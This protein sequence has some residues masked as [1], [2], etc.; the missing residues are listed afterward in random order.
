MSAKMYIHVKYPWLV[1]ETCWNIS[2]IFRRVCVD[3]SLHTV[4]FTC[5]SFFSLLLQFFSRSH[6][7]EE[8]EKR[9]KKAK[10]GYVGVFP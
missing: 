1:E 2:D 9:K 5:S 8:E 3:E 10:Y 6:S 7:L 4:T